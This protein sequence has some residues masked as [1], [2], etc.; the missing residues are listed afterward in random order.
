MSAAGA[1][2]CVSVGKRIATEARYHADGA[3]GL[4]LWRLVAD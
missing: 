1:G 4:A 2:L 3:C